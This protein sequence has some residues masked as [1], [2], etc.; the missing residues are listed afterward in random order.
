MI[1]LRW[2]WELI[3]HF[4]MQTKESGFQRT[5]K[6]LNTTFWHKAQCMKQDTVWGGNATV[7]QESI[8]IKTQ[9]KS[10]KTTW[11]NVRKKKRKEKGKKKRMKEKRK[12]KI[13]PTNLFK[14]YIQIFHYVPVK[15]HINMLCF[16]EK[17]KE[18]ESQ[19]KFS[20]E[21]VHMR[22]LLEVFTRLS[23][24]LFHLLKKSFHHLI[25]K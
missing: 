4:Y 17:L 25:K 9:H 14:W 2:T 3:L 7:R 18:S 21:Y 22:M 24:I 8:R 20:C 5:V 12:K 23:A 15:I 13:K 1:V 16:T 19:M 10:M 11:T 6:Y